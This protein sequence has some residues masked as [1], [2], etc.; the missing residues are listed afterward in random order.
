MFAVDSY[1]MNI[2]PECEL[3]ANDTP[4]F[5]AKYLY[6]GEEALSSSEQQYLGQCD[7]S[8]GGNI[9]YLNGTGLTEDDICIDL[10]NLKESH[11]YIMDLYNVTE[12]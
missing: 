8:F 3:D 10:P 2:T 1:I 6:K 9:Y 7:V 5:D 12:E 11:D 4:T